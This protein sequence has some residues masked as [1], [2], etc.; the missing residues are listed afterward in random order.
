MPQENGVLTI[1]TVKHN[2]VL[3]THY[4]GTEN[5]DV[6]AIV[7]HTIGVADAKHYAVE[8]ENAVLWAIQ[9]YG[10]LPTEHEQDTHST[11][12]D[13][14]KQTKVKIP[15]KTDSDMLDIG[16]GLNVQN[17]HHKLNNPATKVAGKYKN[18]FNIK[19][20]RRSYG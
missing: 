14:V 2:V 19:K 13:M 9:V 15:V 12:Q 8:M 18:I 5:T 17:V 16:I 20:G 10:V 3:L 7:K 1:Q 4:L 11:V 6:L